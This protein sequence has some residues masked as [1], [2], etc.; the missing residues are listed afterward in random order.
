MSVIISIIAGLW[1]HDPL[2]TVYV[3]A[4]SV[5]AAF[6]VIK[7]KRRTCLL[8]A[9][10]F[11]SIV[12]I[13][14]ALTTILAKGSSTNDIG[15]ITLMAFI[16]GFLVSTLVSV[17]LPLLEYLFG[18]TTNISLL[19]WLDL[20]QPLMKSLLVNAPGT[21]HHSI[22]TANL[23]EAAA[24]AV[25]VNPLE[26]RVGAYYHDIGKMKMPEYFIENQNGIYNR[27]DRLTPTMSSLILIA[28]VKEGV[29]LAKKHKLPKIIRDIIQQHH[30]TSLIKYFYQKAKDMTGSSENNIISEENFRYP[31]PKPQTKAA[32]IVMLADN[33]EAAARVLDNPTPARISTLVDTI[34][35]NIFLD[36]QLDE[37][38]LTLKDIH[39]I[40]K[41][42]AYILT[43]LH[44]R[45][46]DYPGVNLLPISP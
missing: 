34:V 23:A 26:A 25:G 4:G 15:F 35:N 46:V 21:Y 5:T 44:H 22:I 14:S 36:G 10:L 28:H 13:F 9:G 31:G 33:V 42:F 8:K 17:F 24:E 2:Y 16:N 30:G 32:A 12:N 3:I 29:E 1:L 39:N 27:H 7:C 37:C 11:I 20:N 18:L 45:R 19:E 41:K 6:S 40:K 38:D 43:G